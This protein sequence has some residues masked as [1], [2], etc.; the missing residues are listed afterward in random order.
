MK[1]LVDI[2]CG[3]NFY[4]I[5]AISLIKSRWFYFGMGKFS[6]RKQYRENNPLFH[7]FST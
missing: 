6:G 2:S 3:G 1:M 4:G 5:T 7:V